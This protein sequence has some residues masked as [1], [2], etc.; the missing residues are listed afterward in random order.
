MHPQSIPVQGEEQEP[1]S[2]ADPLPR[3]R[4]AVERSQTEVACKGLKHVAA[5]AHAHGFAQ[6]GSTWEFLMEELGSGR[7]HAPALAR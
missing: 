3:W 4:T 7:V 1:P 6:T 5:F 2:E